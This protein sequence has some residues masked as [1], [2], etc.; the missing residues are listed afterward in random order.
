MTPL[1]LQWGFLLDID[2]ASACGEIRSGGPQNTFNPVN[3]RAGAFG[4]RWKLTILQL[5]G[6]NPV[7]QT[8]QVQPYN[9]LRCGG[10][11]RKS[12]PRAF[13]EGFSRGK[14]TSRLPIGPASSNAI[15]QGVRCP[16]NGCGSAWYLALGSLMNSLP[17]S[18]EQCD[19]PSAPALPVR[20]ILTFPRRV[21]DRT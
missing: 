8:Y 1:R 18:G 17:A 21:I 4:K 15:S 3:P 5:A 6:S 2:A 10:L 9:V 20:G 12:S 19:G 13:A 16:L 11:L 14:S 7:A